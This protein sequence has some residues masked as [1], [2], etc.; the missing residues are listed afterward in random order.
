MSN[1]LVFESV[2]EFFF[3]NFFH[4]K[5]CKSLSPCKKRVLRQKIPRSFFYFS[6]LPFEQKIFLRNSESR[7]FFLVLCRYD[8]TYRLWILVVFYAT[9]GT[10]TGAGKKSARTTVMKNTIT[11]HHCSS[12]Q[13]D[14]KLKNYTIFWISKLSTFL[15]S[16]WLFY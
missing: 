4:G 8:L 6:P 16:T 10:N 11:S 14:R 7:D 12:N 15:I 1:P 13:N 2:F 9:S 3:Q 5:N